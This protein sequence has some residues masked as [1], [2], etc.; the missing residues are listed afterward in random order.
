[1]HL[2]V[3]SIHNI[4]RQ[5]SIDHTSGLGDWFTYPPSSTKIIEDTWLNTVETILSPLRN[6]DRSGCNWYWKSADGYHRQCY[7]LFVTWVRNYLDQVMVFQVSY[8]ASPIYDIPDIALIGHSSFY[9][10][11][12]SREQHDYLDL[13]EETDK[14]VPKTQGF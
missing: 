2:R 13:L 5:A 14:D 10:L 1:M 3:E 12:N 4:I 9:T 6:L 7:P 11:D 8:I